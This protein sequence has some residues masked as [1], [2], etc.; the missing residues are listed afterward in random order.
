ML[1]RQN[2]CD[3]LIVGITVIV[4]SS[5]KHSSIMMSFF[6][7]S[8]TTSNSV[9]APPPKEERR[10]HERRVSFNS[11]AKVKSAPSPVW[12][13]EER[14]DPSELWWTASDYKSMKL[15]CRVAIYRKMHSRCDSDGETETETDSS[16]GGDKDNENNDSCC[17][18]LER[19]MDGGKSR[20]QIFNAYRAV[21]REQTRHRLDDVGKDSDL[22]LAKVYGAQC[23][24]SAKKAQLFGSAD[25]HEAYDALQTEWT[26][27]SE[28]STKP[29]TPPVTPESCCGSEENNS[30]L[31]IAVESKSGKRKSS[32]IRSLER[33]PFR[34]NVKLTIA[35]MMSCRRHAWI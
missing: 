12:D 5:S 3:K 11:V 32:S 24:V 26:S 29:Q 30:N 7:G 20:I 17:R 18:G 6:N 8:S 9:Q 28:A 31:S 16:S 15:R 1:S 2:F 23:I 21:R 4:Q 27:L 33:S 35:N 10:E 19:L 22:A 25:A 13:A 34:E 14:I